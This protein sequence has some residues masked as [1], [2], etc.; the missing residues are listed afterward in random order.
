MKS[1]AHA[2]VRESFYS[3]LFIGVLSLATAQV[4]G[5]KEISGDDDLCRTINDPAAGDEVI[6]RPGDYRGPC[7]LRRGGSADRPLVIRAKNLEQRPRIV[8][9]G[10]SSNVIKI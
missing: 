7:R 2:R 8:Y 10:D 1:V 9:E 6:L 3:L 4:A 5:A